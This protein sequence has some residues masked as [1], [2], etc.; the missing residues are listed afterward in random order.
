MA[1]QEIPRGVRTVHFEAKLPLAVALCE[2]DVVEH[3][4]GVKQLRIENQ[5]VPLPALGGPE[6]HPRGMVKQQI[7]LGIANELSDLA[8]H[9]AVG[10]AYAGNVVS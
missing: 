1:S 8:R 7:T 4:C 9:F 5:A 2:P 6:E 3:G 10:N